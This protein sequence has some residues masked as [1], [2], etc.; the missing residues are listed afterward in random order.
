MLEIE[1]VKI[2]TDFS[3]SIRFTRQG[4][5]IEYT[6][7]SKKN[8]VEF[9]RCSKKETRIQE[10]LF[11]D[12]NN[13]DGKKEVSEEEFSLMKSLHYIFSKLGDNHD[14]SVIDEKDEEVAILWAEKKA[15][16]E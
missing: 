11:K 6:Q 5:D 3:N 10:S 8:D 12:I 7:G 14:G 4:K 9:T 13:I 15:E 2:M 1:G 16:L